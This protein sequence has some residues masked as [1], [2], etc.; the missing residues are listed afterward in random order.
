MNRANLRSQIADRYYD[1]KMF[2]LGMRHPAFPVCFLVLIIALV[3][4]GVWIPTIMWVVYLA[5][6][7][8]IWV[9]TIVALIRHRRHRP[10]TR[11]RTIAMSQMEGKYNMTPLVT[12]HKTLDN[13]MVMLVVLSTIM[14]VKTIFLTISFVLV[15]L[16]FITPFYYV[17][18]ILEDLAFCIIL[19][20]PETVMLFEPSRHMPEA[21]SE[22]MNSDTVNPL[23]LSQHQ[24]DQQ[25]AY[26]NQYSGQPNE[27]HE[28]ITMPAQDQEANAPYLAAQNTQ[29]GNNEIRPVAY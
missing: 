10:P 8:A 11:E 29:Q 23:P 3:I 15:L 18:C 5:L 25:V 2:D 12:S 17:F 6:F 9:T 26:H 20:S 14:L 19:S 4:A 7:F 24:H 22:M 1:T 28:A 13:M 21:R 27:N 16:F